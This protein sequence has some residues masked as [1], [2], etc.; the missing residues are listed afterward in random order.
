MLIS[1]N[2]VTGCVN[3]N[4]CL[5]NPHVNSKPSGVL[6]GHMTSVVQVEY[7]RS[8]GQAISISKVSILFYFI[9]FYKVSISSFYLHCSMFLIFHYAWLFWIA[10]NW[11]W[12]DEIT[13]QLDYENLLSH[14]LQIRLYS[15]ISMHYW[16]ITCLG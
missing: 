5:W 15:Q 2:I 6:R 8:R 10:W 1:L 3:N 7:I 13:S 16:N 9:L 4:V 14:F 11:P 12:L